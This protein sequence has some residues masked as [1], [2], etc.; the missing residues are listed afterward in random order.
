MQD[1]IEVEKQ[2]QANCHVLPNDLEKWQAEGWRV[3]KPVTTKKG[4]KDDG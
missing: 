1:R 2:G 3:V 4:S